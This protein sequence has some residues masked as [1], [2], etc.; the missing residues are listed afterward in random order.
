M[1]ALAA[2][3]PTSLTNGLTTRLA[4][5]IIASGETTT[6]PVEVFTGAPLAVL[7]TSSAEDVAAAVA[8]ARRAQPGWAA[9]DLGERRRVVRAFAGLVLAERNTLLDLVQ[10]E[11]GKARWDAFNEVLEPVL[12]ANYYLRKS[13]ALLRPQRREG[14]L[15]LLVR[16]EERRGPKGVVGIISPWNYP[17]ALSI[18]DA[19]PALLAGNAV[20]VK[21]D[22]QTSLSP[23]LGAELLER[24]GLP[25]GVFQV[26]VG[27]PTTGGALVDHADYIGFTG[28]SGSGRVVAER[29]AARLIGCSL[30][31]GGKNAM[32]V[33][34]DADVA[35]AVAAALP[36]CFTNAGQVCMAIE[37]VYVHHDLYDEFTARFV[38]ATRALRLG[39]GYDFGY[40]VGALS[41]P[42]QLDVV[43]AYLDD[44]VS[45]GAQV[46]TGGRARPDLGPT[47]FEPT[48]LTGVTSSM[49]CSGAEVFGPVVAVAPFED[50]E[51]A[52]RLANDSEYGLNASVFGRDTERARRLGTRLRA[53]TVNINDGFIAAYG[54]MDAPMGGMGSSGLGRR[55]GAEGLLKYTE[56]QTVAAQRG[57]WTQPPRWLPRARYAAVMARAVRVLAK[58]G[59]R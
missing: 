27:G 25:S 42:R 15:P 33:L 8:A 41:S 34:D 40:D 24:A 4:E 29:A 26:V 31:L 50:D 39:H 56:A 38:A 59:I 2:G 45:L 9:T 28:S 53:G 10:A 36:A 48:I 43:T 57:A 3:L 18:S 21:P 17:F 58:A 37:R 32:I 23:L 7:P 47:F 14:M 46:R 30:E 19:I 22:S 20:V 13:A 35:K 44:A 49:A 54:S 52:L 55:H 5:R 1:T 11:T 16:A 12:T 6:R 51:Q